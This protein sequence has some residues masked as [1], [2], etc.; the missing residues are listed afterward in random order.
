MTLRL[1]TVDSVSHCFRRLPPH[2]NRISKLFKDF[3]RRLPVNASVSDANTLLQ[4][5]W[6]LRRDF[7][8]ALVD[9]GFDHNT[10]D[11]SLAFPKLV[12][13]YSSDLRLVPVVFVRVSCV[14]WSAYK[15]CLVLL[16]MSQCLPWEQSI[17][18][19]SGLPF[20]LSP[21]RVALTLSRSKFVPL[22]PPRSITKQCSLPLVRVMAAKPCFVTPM[23]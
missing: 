11:T 12:A 19:T 23:K 4:A 14:L 20:F 3:D 1:V 6:A 21:S 15:R 9:V 7:L 10:N 8:V 16:K 13:D 17:I 5:G 2:S 22:V 18:I